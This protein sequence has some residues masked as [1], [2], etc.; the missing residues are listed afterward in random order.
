MPDTMHGDKRRDVL[1]CENPGYGVILE[2]DDRR[3][4]WSLQSGEHRVEHVAGM[5]RSILSA[6]AARRTRPP[7]IGNAGSRL[8]PA[9]EMLIHLSFVKNGPATRARPA[10]LVFVPLTSESPRVRMLGRH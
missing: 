1:H 8:N 7:S 4:F 3:G 9:N 10:G 5:S 2:Y 6:S